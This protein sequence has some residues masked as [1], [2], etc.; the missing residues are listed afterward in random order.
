MA[1]EI[2]KKIVSNFV[3]VTVDV[4]GPTMLGTWASAGAMMTKFRFNIHIQ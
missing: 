4:D 3:V 1:K 2:W